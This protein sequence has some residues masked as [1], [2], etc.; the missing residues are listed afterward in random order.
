MK[1]YKLNKIIQ[2]TPSMNTCVQQMLLAPR[3]NMHHSF[4]CTYVFNLL[5]VNFWCIINICITHV[6]AKQVKI[7]QQ[8]MFVIA[9]HMKRKY[10][11]FKGRTA[12]AGLWLDRH[13][14]ETGCLCNS[15]VN[16]QMLQCC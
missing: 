6:T 7:T 5:S 12:W 13:F 11:L 4:S 14:R 2:Y 1:L 3:Y 10:I 9:K 16:L 8:L 15:V